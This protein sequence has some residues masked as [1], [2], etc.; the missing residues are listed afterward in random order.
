MKTTLRRLL[1]PFLAASLVLAMVFPAFGT[2]L[3]QPMEQTAAYLLQIVPDPQV[4]S[5]GGEWSVIGLARSGLEV[6]PSWY[7]TYLSN[8]RETLTANHGVLSTRKNT[9]YARAV[10]ALAA[11]GENPRNA[12]GYD[13]IAPL[14][15]VDK[16]VSQGLNG[17]IYALIA[18]DSGDYGVDPR[19]KEQYLQILTDAQLPDGGWALSG[20]RGDP[21]LTAMALQALS[22]HTSEVPDLIPGGM[23]CLYS[24][25]FKSGKMTTLESHAQMLMAWAALGLEPTQEM[26]DAFLS[27]QRSDGSF[28]HTRG[29]RS[30]LMA[31][32]QGLCALAALYRYEAEAPGLYDMSDAQPLQPEEHSSI[33]PQYFTAIPVMAALMPASVLGFTLPFAGGAR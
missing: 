9:E 31:T 18:L 2:D 22:P 15:D 12:W 14:E 5:T 23:I 28:S 11:L 30:D 19:V 1:S 26:I 4:S 10:L 32:E 27:Y 7:R 17:A 16:T 24:D 33:S 25:W 20:N 8:L 21:D 6:G 29:G 3:S 13:L